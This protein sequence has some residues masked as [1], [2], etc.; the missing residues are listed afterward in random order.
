MIALQQRTAKWIWVFLFSSILLFTL[1]QSKAQAETEVYVVYA[2]K[3]NLG[4]NKLMAALPKNISAKAFNINFLAFADYSGKQKMVTRLNRSKMV[5][6]MSDIPML[7]LKNARITTNLLITQSSKQTIRS[8]VWTLHVLEEGLELKGF[9]DS[10]QKKLISKKTDL[11]SYEDL[12]T[13][14]LLIVN[15]KTIPLFEVI[16][17]VVGK[18]IRP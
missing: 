17:Q 12:R 10:V 14:D 3:G 9:G 15:E 16:S 4:K 11:G 5:I 7:L 8:K 6:F 18:T 2:G 13:L 1:T